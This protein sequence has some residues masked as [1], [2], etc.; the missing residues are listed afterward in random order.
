VIPAGPDLMALVIK[1]GEF[2]LE[3]GPFILFGAVLAAAQMTLLP[4]HRGAWSGERLIS[5]VAALP[6]GLIAVFA[7][8]IRA[9]LWRATMPASPEPSPSEP[10]I[11]RSVGYI[12]SIIVP[13]LAV[14]IVGAVIVILTPVEPLWSLLAAPSPWRIVIAPLAVGLVRPRSGTELPLVLALITKG[15]DPAGAAAAIA[16]CGYTRAATWTGR[17]LHVLLGI[18]T[19][20]LAWALGFTTW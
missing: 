6:L 2:L 20:L 3:I 4:A 12:D 19:G 9:P 7:A 11:R 18:G 15:L 16:G 14:S 8:A 13:F 10:L 5:T 17:A 1:V